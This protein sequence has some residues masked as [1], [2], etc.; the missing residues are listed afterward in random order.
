MI[1]L[2]CSS[3]VKKTELTFFLRKEENRGWVKLAVL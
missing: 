2:K 3:E 1:H